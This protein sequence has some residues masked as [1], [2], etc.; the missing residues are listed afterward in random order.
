[1]RTVG[2]PT[3]LTSYEP[4]ACVGCWKMELFE[5][6][7]PTT[8]TGRDHSINPESDDLESS[9]LITVNMSDHYL[10]DWVWYG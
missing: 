6:P 4:E 3:K 8:L 5:E 9:A 1:M 7:I 2:H 10:W